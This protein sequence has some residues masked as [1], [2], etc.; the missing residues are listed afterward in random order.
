MYLTPCM[1]SVYIVPSAG[2]KSLMP[3]NIHQITAGKRLESHDE[4]LMSIILVV[5]RY[6]RRRYCDR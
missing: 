4:Q 3:I 2:P 6:N 5:G 1:R